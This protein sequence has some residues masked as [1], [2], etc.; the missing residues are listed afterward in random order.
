MAR[1]IGVDV[2]G[3]DKT[4]SAFASVNAGIGRL[5]KTVSGL[6]LRGIGMQKAFMFGERALMGVARATSEAVREALAYRDANDATAK[7][8]AGWTKSSD[9]LQRSIGDALLP[10]VNV[11]ATAGDSLAESFS[12]W[13]KANDGILRQ[14]MIKWAGDLANVMT[15]GV[16]TAVLA[17]SKAAYTLQASVL[18]VRGT[19]AELTGDT[20]FADQIAAE[21]Y[22]AEQAQRAFEESVDQVTAK[23]ADAVGTAQVKAYR[24]LG[25]EIRRTSKAAKELAIDQAA[26]FANIDAAVDASFK[27]AF[28]KEKAAAME[29]LDYF[30]AI[31]QRDLAITQ[32][33]EEQKAQAAIDASNR[34][35]EAQAAA[36]AEWETMSKSTLAAIGGQL[37]AS[38][39]SAITGTESLGEAFGSLAQGI[40]TTVMNS[41][42]NVAI[43]HAIEA[44]TGAA[45]SQAAI[46]IVGPAL[47]LA[48]MGAIFAAVV[49]FA[50]SQM[51]PAKG[52][53]AGGI[54][55]GG[56]PGR[57]SVPAVLMP[58]EGVLPSNLTSE[59]RRVLAVQG[60]GGSGGVNVSA[61]VGFM[62]IP[63]RAQTRQFIL[64]NLVPELK[65]MKAA[66]HL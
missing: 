46:P 11:L 7:A 31:R 20:E 14:D 41:A 52:M 51:K 18:A 59:L 23:I 9:Q 24:D 44:A 3:T 42:I 6:T 64:E 29:R 50:R 15:T 37:T 22:Q 47:A 17:A 25:D 49:G 10:A 28:E 55:T 2:E 38:I 33:M 43:A 53:A 57:D 35:F 21:M 34:A 19:M 36:Q 60:G 1:K 61:S 40:A 12:E 26:A 63:S 27:S 56:V 30:T 54:V 13:M 58:G 32:R 45:S 48:S 65:R 62:A 16:A 66:G 5:D 39:T 8:V 4:A